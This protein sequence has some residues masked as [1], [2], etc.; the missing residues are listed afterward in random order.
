MAHIRYMKTPHI[1]DCPACVLDAAPPDAVGS[2]LIFCHCSYFF[3]KSGGKFDFAIKSCGE[4]CGGTFLFGNIG[5]L[6]DS[7]EICLSFSQ[8]CIFLECDENTV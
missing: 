5:E 7:F 2:S 8:D 1:I 6:G 3:L 4:D